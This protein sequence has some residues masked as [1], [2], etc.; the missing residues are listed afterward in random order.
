MWLS[1]T[2][3]NLQVTDGCVSP[4]KH[5]QVILIMGW[6]VGC[7]EQP[8]H[9]VGLSKSSDFLIDGCE[10]SPQVHRLAFGQVND[11]TFYRAANFYGAGQVLGGYAV[12]E[13]I[14]PS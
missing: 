12:R 8:Y 13:N 7:G 1:Y 14:P 4:S 11:A 2:F 3:N 5:V 9:F 6:I 10:N